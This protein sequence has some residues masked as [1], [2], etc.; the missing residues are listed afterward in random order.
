MTFRAV[1]IGLVLALVSAA[2]A[3]NME[4]VTI[5]DAGNAVDT[6]FMSTDGTTGYGS[7]G[8]VHR[9]GKYEVT[10]A[11]VLRVAQRGS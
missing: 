7:V 11:Q 2:M 1:F 6:E 10:N 9:M 5:G 3:V 8:Y 4:Y